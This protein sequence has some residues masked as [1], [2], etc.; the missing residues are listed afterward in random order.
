[1]TNARRSTR[2][3][4][5]VGGGIAGLAAAHALSV[6]ADAPSVTVFE[7]SPTLGGKIR[8][9]PFAGHPRI[10]EGAD[11]FLARVPWATDLARAVGLGDQL[12]SPASGH[13]AVWRNKLHSIPAGLLLGMPTEVLAL[14]RSGLLSWRGKARA[15]I[16]PLLPRT[17]LADDS[18]G[19]F[20]RG[21]FGDEV[22]EQLVDP[23]VGSIYAADTD[24]FSLTAVPQIAELATA[25]RSVLLAS[26]HRA[27]VPGGPVFFTPQGG[28]GDLV[29]AI[30]RAVVDVGGVIRTD[31]P[32]ECLE[33]AG[34][35]WRVVG[36]GHSTD[37]LVF[38]AVLLA[39][40]AAATAQL[41]GR[42]TGASDACELLAGIATADVVLASL[43]V[44]HDSWPS[45]L[46]GMSGYLVPKPQQRLVT[47]VS[48]GSQKWSHW[49]LPDQHILRVSLGRDALPILHL[50]DEEVVTAA[51]GE[52]TRHLG[53]D[54]QPTSVRISRW[55]GAFPQ[56]RPHHHDVV[57]A[58]Q[59]DLPAGITLAGASYHGIGIPAC[60]R[61]AQSAALVTLRHIDSLAD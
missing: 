55:P 51:V 29:D 59:R 30:A 33:P 37:D 2:R 50:S 9:T 58:A 11:A 4:A 22:H 28:L 53:A 24:R 49:A 54:L 52:V 46:Q 60:I 45:R 17:S 8:T 19:A 27:A 47:A 14:S 21:R 23:L 43:A 42:G 7:A 39:S 13:A 10:D 48:F 15:A 35:Q 31:A 3:V 6:A 56:Y 40:P 25:S 1:M 5:V 20:V 16:E 18:L 12:V 34:A 32:V 57:A 44:P 41:L 26:R 36:G 38:D 61:S